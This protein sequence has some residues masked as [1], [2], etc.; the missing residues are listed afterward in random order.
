MS[1]STPEFTRKNDLFAEDS[2][3]R[4]SRSQGHID[5]SGLPT[6]VAAVAE[7]DTLTHISQ[8]IITSQRLDKLLLVM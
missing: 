5:S 8:H 6:L 4:S 7:W 3:R 2:A 1:P